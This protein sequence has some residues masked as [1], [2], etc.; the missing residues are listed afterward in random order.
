MKH[1]STIIS[2]FLI[3]CALALF[4]CCSSDDEPETSPI[5][6][7][8]EKMTLEYKDETFTFGDVPSQARV[9][10]LGIFGA[11]IETSGKSIENKNDWEGGS[12]SDKTGMDRGSADANKLFT[13]DPDTD[14]F[15]EI[16]YEIP[17]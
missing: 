17:V 6:S 4:P 7:G 13:Y 14:N 16:D 11:P 5:F 15:T 12:H 8:V 9:L 3:T 1:I 2:L 10:V